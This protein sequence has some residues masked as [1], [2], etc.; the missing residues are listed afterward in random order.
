MTAKT[1]RRLVPALV[2]AAFAVAPVAAQAENVNKCEEGGTCPRILENGTETGLENGAKLPILSWGTLQLKNT[3]LGLITCHNA[4][5]GSASDP[6]VKGPGD[7]RGTGL[8]EGYTAYQCKGPLCEVAGEPVEVT[9]L[10]QAANPVTKAKETVG[11]IT[12][13]WESK[14]LEPVAKEWKLDVGNKTAGSET[15]IRFRVVC[16]AQALA[17]EFTGELAPV[18]EAGTAIGSAPGKLTFSEAS[19]ELE[20]TVGSGTVK[21]TVKGLGYAAQEDIEVANQ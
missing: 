8:V 6:G 4:F 17:A 12:V 19:G 20:G 9:P 11:R 13:P 1:A 14:V 7:A 21:G 3:K 2:I 15:K 10:G 18:G 5:A 16:A